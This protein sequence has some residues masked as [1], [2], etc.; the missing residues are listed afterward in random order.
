MCLCVIIVI[1][2]LEMVSFSAG[3]RKGSQLVKSHSVISQRF[4]FG[5][6]LAPERRPV[7]QKVTLVLAVIVATFLTN[8]IQYVQ[9]FTVYKK[10]SHIGCK[11]WA[12]VDFGL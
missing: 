4:S 5:D 12:A 9:L 6:L 10:K 7:K 2:E 1:S 8:V 3:I 11:C